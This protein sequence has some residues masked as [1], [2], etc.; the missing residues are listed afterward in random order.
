M[1]NKEKID[2]L[3]SSLL[4]ENDITKHR[5]SIITST[6]LILEICI[7]KSDG[8]MDLDTCEKISSLISEVLD[9]NN[10]SD[11]KYTLDVCSFGAE[12]VLDNLSDVINHINDYV[13]IELRNPT[14]GLDQLEGY[15][16]E[17]V[18]NQLSVEYMVK[19]IKKTIEIEYDNIKLIRLAVKF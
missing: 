19:N 11:S 16:K 1:L 13:H 3:I 2:E 4:I 6:E 15:L 8:S 18:N 5:I 9:A 10:I 17:V 12:E 7:K 14:K